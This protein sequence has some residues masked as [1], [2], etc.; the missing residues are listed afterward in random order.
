M[1]TGIGMS[2]FSGAYSTDVKLIFTQVF[3][4]FLR[5]TLKERKKLGIWCNFLS[6]GR[7]NRYVTKAYNLV[8]EYPMGDHIVGDIATYPFTLE[9][10]ESVLFVN[11]WDPW[12][13]AG[14]GNGADNSL[15]GQ[16]GRRSAIA[17]LCSPLTNEYITN[18]NYIEV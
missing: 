15:D 17:C 8:G 1:F 13:F 2:A 7:K 16:I 4:E 18:I 10:P 9:D 5:K 12:S 3:G 14:N 11:A 6:Y